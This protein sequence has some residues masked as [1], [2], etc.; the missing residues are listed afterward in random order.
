M[1]KENNMRKGKILAIAAIFVTLAFSVADLS[2]QAK[3]R[4]K[5]VKP[6]PVVSATTP[7]T[8]PLIISR[9]EDFPDTESRVVATSVQ[10]EPVAANNQVPS[11]TDSLDDLRERIKTLE[12]NRKKDTD[13]KQKRLLLN[14]DIL[15]KSEQRVESL[16]KQLFDMIEKENA[17]KLRLD[18]I[19]NDI[20]PEAI[21]RQIAI[22]GSLRPEDLRTQR[23]KNLESEKTNLQ[24]LLTEVQ[25]NRTNL[26]LNVTR[27]DTMV[28]RLR[29]KLEKEIDTALADETPDNQ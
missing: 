14:L 28:E 6:T 15:T 20:R 17:I 27:A 19:D 2:A 16:R 11:S 7:A 1:A 8:E 9:A 5:S 26:E 4:K 24:V 10:T 21:D 12:T 18:I 22:A 13:E 3:R 25:K 29:G 23:K